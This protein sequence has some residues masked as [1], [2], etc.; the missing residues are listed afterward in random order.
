MH[1]F[2]KTAPL[3]NKSYQIR[4]NIQYLIFPIPKRDI[5]VVEKS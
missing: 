2:L 5:L 1:F 3:P 4:K